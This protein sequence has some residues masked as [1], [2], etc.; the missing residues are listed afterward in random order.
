VR[1]TDAHKLNLLWQCGIEMMLV[2][3]LALWLGCK[4]L[5]ARRLSHVNGHSCAVVVR[6]W[7]ATEQGEH[8]KQYTVLVSVT[9]MLCCLCCFLL[10]WQHGVAECEES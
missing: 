9:S 10:C 5:A 2:V 8:R 3:V 4:W 7:L 1:A 6:L